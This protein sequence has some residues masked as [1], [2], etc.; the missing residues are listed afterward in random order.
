[1][2]LSN[3]LLIVAA[4]AIVIFVEYKSRASKI[5]YDADKMREDAKPIGISH[6]IVGPNSKRRYRTTVTFSDGFKYISHKTN[7]DYQFLTYKISVPDEMKDEIVM[8]AIE[9]HQ[10]TF[11]KLK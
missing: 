1:M 2:E 10:R 11:E 3:L 8:D 9:A 7:V 6:D 5:E 4:I